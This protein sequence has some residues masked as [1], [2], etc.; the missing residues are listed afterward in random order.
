MSKTTIVQNPNPWRRWLLPA[1][2]ALI[3]VAILLGAFFATHPHF[4]GGSPTN[5]P[6]ATVKPTATAT[7]IP[8][9]TPAKAKKPPT[10][11]PKP[12][13][14][15]TPKPTNTPRPAPTATQ[16]PAPTP[17][18]KPTP[19]TT[20]TPVALLHTGKVTYLPGQLQLI[21]QRA[22]ANNPAYTYYLNPVQVLQ[23]D[24]PKN[25]F[26]TGTI[27][28]ISP[29]PQP[30]PTPY[31]NSQ[32]FP[33]VQY[34]VQYQGKRYQITLDQPQQTGPKGIWVIMQIKAL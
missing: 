16:R 2:L 6:T 33:E 1:L 14:T 5:T 11:T 25:G 26:S 13:P 9:A 12:A 3:V 29:A 34:V 28:V 21:Q 32:G 15:S 7:L 22:S 20:A 10:S 8:T 4:F 30:T 19:H 18:P 17:T 23:H 31:T 24:L 27:T